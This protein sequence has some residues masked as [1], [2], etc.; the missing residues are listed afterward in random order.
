M[1][2]RTAAEKLVQV[3]HSLDGE[4]RQ[5]NFGYRFR[6]VETNVRSLAIRGER[7]DRWAHGLLL[8]V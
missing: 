4:I 3:G 6:K 5:V 1:P 2:G 8:G 7:E